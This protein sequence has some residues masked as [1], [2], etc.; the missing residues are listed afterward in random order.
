MQSTPRCRQTPRG[1]APLKAPPPKPADAQDPV[2]HPT[3]AS[4]Q[5]TLPDFDDETA[6]AGDVDGGVTP[7]NQL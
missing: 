7:M 3:L 2:V 1:V 4:V 5:G 6:A